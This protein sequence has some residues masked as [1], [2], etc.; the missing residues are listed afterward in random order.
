MFSFYFD[1][2]HILFLFAKISYRSVIAKPVFFKPIQDH[3]E[4]TT[5]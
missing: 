4:Q 3:Q 5:N 1:T 2:H